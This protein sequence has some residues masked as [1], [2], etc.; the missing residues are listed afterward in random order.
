LSILSGIG[1]P[2]KY[3]H[4][5]VGYIEARQP[6]DRIWEQHEIELA[7]LPLPQAADAVLLTQWV[8]RKLAHAW[9]MR[10][11]T[12]PMAREGHAGNGLHFHFSPVKD[13]EHLDIRADD[14]ELSESAR[15]LIG[16]L[17]RSGGALMAF[18]NRVEE[19][20]ARLSQ[21]KEAP[22]SI[23][24]G[25]FDRSAL[26]RLP[27]VA[28]AE[29]GRRVTVPTIEFRLPDG[30]ALP[31]LLLAGVTQA[32][33]HA[34]DVEDLDRLVQRTNSAH[35]RKDPSVATPVPRNFGEVAE[36][37]VTHRKEFEEDGVFPAV[38]IDSLVSAMHSRGI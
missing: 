16:G 6:D 14:G 13:G 22:S 18:G 23:V 20:F 7:L 29:D 15:W 36:A 33:T 38:L 35:A 27:T 5:E 11:D 4:S 34:M 26:V 30:S 32:M 9:G 2:V 24:W 25:D 8:L 21:A 31:H 12:S 37:L 3:G 1:V 28:R 17:V 19:S 10:C